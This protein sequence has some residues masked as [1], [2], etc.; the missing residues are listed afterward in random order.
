[1]GILEKVE[2]RKHEAALH[3]TGLHKF[4][5]IAPF[6][7]LSLFILAPT[8]NLIT[9]EATLNNEAI[10]DIL[11]VYAILLLVMAYIQFKAL[12]RISRIELE[13]F[14]LKDDKEQN[15]K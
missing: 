8:F 14:R 13:L 15:E 5:E 9:R 3:R 7:F 11:F 1:M 12:R 6:L 10:K 2:I 4:A